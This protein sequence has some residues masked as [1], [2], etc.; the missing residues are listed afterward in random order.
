MYLMSLSSISTLIFTPLQLRC[1]FMEAE[2][3]PG[4]FVDNGRIFIEISDA[5]R[6]RHPITEP[7]VHSIVQKE[8]GVYY[9][10]ADTCTREK[11]LR[12]LGRLVMRSGPGVEN[13]K[14]GFRH[15]SSNC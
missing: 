9:T 6:A 7:N 11:W 13:G 5:D 10:V 2:E 12:K 3:F 14:Y 1:D 15:F 4:M 8:D